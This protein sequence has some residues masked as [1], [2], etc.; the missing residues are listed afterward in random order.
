M[1]SKIWLLVLLLLFTLAPSGQAGDSDQGKPWAAQ[2]AEFEGRQ[3]W[4]ELLKHT[5]RWTRSLPN[6]YRAWFN[7]GLAQ[8]ELDMAEQAAA[9]YRQALRLKPQYAAAW[10]NLG[11]VLSRLSQPEAAIDAFKQA[12]ELQ[13]RSPEA[14]FALGAAYAA[15]GQLDEL[16]E[17]HQRLDNL[18]PELAAEFARKFL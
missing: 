13:P 14:W 5:F 10:L 12:T 11:K 1:R 7:M 18:V 15:S 6:D 16:A 17:I 9:S 4:T 2:A 8:A 3:E